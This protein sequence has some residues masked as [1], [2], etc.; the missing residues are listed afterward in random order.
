[1]ESYNFSKPEEVERFSALPERERRQHI[2]F[3]RNYADDINRRI[4]VGEEKNEQ[5]ALETIEQEK[6]DFRMKF[7]TA[8]LDCLKGIAAY[9]EEIFRDTERKEH[10]STVTDIEE[11]WINDIDEQIVPEEREKWDWQGVWT[12]MANTEAI[13]ENDPLA[14]RFLGTKTCEIPS[15][16]IESQLRLRYKL[17]HTFEKIASSN[18]A[19]YSL[20][21]SLSGFLNIPYGQECGIQLGAQMLAPNSSTDS[22]FELFDVQNVLTSLRE[23]FTVQEKKCSF[24]EKHRLSKGC[25]DRHVR[26]FIDKNGGWNGEC[27]L[28]FGG[29]H[30]AAVLK[31][32]GAIDEIVDA[33]NSGYANLS[34]YHVDDR[35]KLIT[36]GNYLEKSPIRVADMICSANTLDTESGIEAMA[37]PCSGVSRK[38]Y[39]LQS[40]MATEELSLIFY[41]QLKDGGFMIHDELGL[42]DDLCEAIGIVNVGE[43]TFSN[44]L[45]DDPKK[46][47]HSSWSDERLH[48]Y[49]KIRKPDIRRFVMGNKIAVYD[50][51]EDLWKL[52]GFRY[53]W[54]EERVSLTSKE[55]IL[56]GRRELEYTADENRPPFDWRT[57]QRIFSNGSMW[58]FRQDGFRVTCLKEELPE[59][60]SIFSADE[61]AWALSSESRKNSELWRELLLNCK[62]EKEQISVSRS[63]PE[64][65]K[66][67]LI[68]V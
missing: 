38:S 14:L 13:I 51:Q 40:I 56:S 52:E 43:F 5:E 25:F 49:K 48:F 24:R 12:E 21:P 65:L 23:S 63:I 54:K 61:I 34:G 10:F 41:G 67:E 42:P 27:V 66:S 7:R 37:R 26:S 32:Y 15:Q 2:N 22:F 36:L 55:F 16:H 39:Y 20:R 8:I 44:G 28:E 33:G 62:S 53:E 31:Q 6:R 4:D 59:L 17:M 9:N 46:L 45:D 60:L 1:M 30:T 11:G 18:G 29:D 35:S 47:A 68:P 50:E 58:D 57:G 3:S 64:E 19:G